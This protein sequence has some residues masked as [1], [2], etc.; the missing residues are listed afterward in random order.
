MPAPTAPEVTTMTS[1]PSLRRV[2][3]ASAMASRRAGSGRPSSATRTRVPNFK[4]M[5]RALASEARIWA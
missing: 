3:M 1:R 4:T 5:R 2:A